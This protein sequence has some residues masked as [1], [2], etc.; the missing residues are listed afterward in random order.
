MDFHECSV[1]TANVPQTEPTIWKPVLEL[2]AVL[3]RYK[4]QVSRTFGVS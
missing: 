2:I 3:A 4:H 1:C